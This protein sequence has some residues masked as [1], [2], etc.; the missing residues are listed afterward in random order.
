MPRIVGSIAARHERDASHAHRNAGEF[1][2]VERLAEEARR[3]Q[4]GEQRCGGIEDRH[5]RRRQRVGRIREQQKRDRRVDHAHEQVCAPVAAHVGLA[6]RPRE[7]RDQHDTGDE[8][9]KRH[10]ADRPHRQGKH[11]E[12]HERRPPDHRQGNQAYNVGR[13]YVHGASANA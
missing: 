9:A 8:H 3:Q 12:E 6:S 2:A 10:G 13:A 7:P 5:D 4:R 1:A 11:A